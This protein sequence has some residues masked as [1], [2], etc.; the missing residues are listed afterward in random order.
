[1]YLTSCAL[2]HPYFQCFALMNKTVLTVSTRTA[3]VLVCVFLLEE[4]WVS[5]SLRGLGGPRSGPWLSVR[6]SCPS[7]STSLPPPQPPLLFSVLPPVLWFAGPCCCPFLLP[8][9]ER[10]PAAVSPA[11]QG[12]QPQPRGYI[13]QFRSPHTGQ[14]SPVALPAVKDAQR[15]GHQVPMSSTHYR[16]RPQKPR[17]RVQTGC[18]Q[19]QGSAAPRR[20]GGGVW[21]PTWRTGQRQ[22]CRPCAAQTDAG[23]RR[24]PRL[25]GGAACSTM[26]SGTRARRGVSV[27]G[28]L[29][30]ACNQLNLTP[31]RS[32]FPSCGWE[33]RPP[34]PQGHRAATSELKTTH[35][36]PAPKPILCT[37]RPFRLSRTWDVVHVAAVPGLR[38]LRAEGSTLHPHGQLPRPLP[39]PFFRSFPTGPQKRMAV[40]GLPP[41]SVPAECPGGGC[42]MKSAINV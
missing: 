17:R 11:V 3:F 41:P 20:G 27:L 15:K 42:R 37:A 9:W 34:P 12:T 35:V 29:L 21:M 38:W 39:G 33:E 7:P 32:R 36:C 13:C 19:G 40:R 6:A 2:V 5:A 22:P 16:K 31:R 14:T 30:A 10:P 18:R 24:G 25:R 26:D 8:G 1:M 28:P 23:W 4:F